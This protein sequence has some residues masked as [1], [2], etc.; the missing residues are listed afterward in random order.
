MLVT[1]L[2]PTVVTQ[3][4]VSGFIL[5]SDWSIRTKSRADNTVGFIEKE[6]DFPCIIISDLLAFNFITPANLV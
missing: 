4:Q 6:E 5:N 2:A 1:D 3:R